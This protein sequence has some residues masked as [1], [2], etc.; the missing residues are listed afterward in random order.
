[1]GIVDLYSKRQ[2]RI[3]GEVPDVYKYSD[4]SSPLRIQI[5]YILN[6]L[7]GTQE[8]FNSHS[9]KNVKLMYKQLVNCLRR[10]YGV[11]RLVE[12]RL[13]REDF[14]SELRMFIE[15]EE[16]VEKCIDAIEISFRLADKFAREFEYRRKRNAGEIVNSCIDEL[17]RRLKEHGVGFEF[18]DG[19]IVRIDSQ[20]VHSEVVKPAMKL[21][22]Q[23]GYEGVRDEF[24]SAY[25]HFRHSKFKE[26]LNDALKSFESMMKTICINND[27]DFDIRDTAKKL[28]NKCVVN[29]LFPEYYQNHLNALFTLL[30]SSVPTIRN[31][32]SGHGQGEE[33]TYVDSS[34]VAY[35]LHMTAAAIVM[36]GEMDSKL[37]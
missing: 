17:N 11:H 36:L 30:E 7:L 14:Y 32:E 19:E 2:K 6:D 16:D 33:I 34:V 35:T 29:G 10:E 4:L 28:I 25:E 20:F 18:I 24:L 23:E 22:N 9:L 3:R 37:N 5:L 1:M 26:S 13:H 15:Y 12:L 8:D 31:K 27:W 21:L